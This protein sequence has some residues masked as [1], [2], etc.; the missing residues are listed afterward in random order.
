MSA[1]E[2][3]TMI[4]GAATSQAFEIKRHIAC[5][6]FIARIYISRLPH[7]DTKGQQRLRH[8]AI[9]LPRP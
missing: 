6:D 8:G 5:M 3:T 4:K 2:K 7:G 1:L 9:F